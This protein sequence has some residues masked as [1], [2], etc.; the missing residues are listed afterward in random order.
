MKSKKATMSEATWQLVQE[1]KVSRNLL[2]DHSQ[3]QRKT[4]LEAW[5]ACWKHV[6]HHC[7]VDN[8]AIACDQL[9]TEQDKLVAV[10]RSC[11]P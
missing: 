10:C 11:I 5:F 6:I 9:L 8:L 2:H 1:K 4:L 3:V 7:E